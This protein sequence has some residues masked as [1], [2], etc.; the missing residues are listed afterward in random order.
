MQ[1]HK[2]NTSIRSCEK[3]FGNGLTVSFAGLQV[4]L[5]RC[6]IMIIEGA[7]KGQGKTKLTGVGSDLLT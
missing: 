7:K 2:I 6:D 3:D 4:N 1:S 5:C